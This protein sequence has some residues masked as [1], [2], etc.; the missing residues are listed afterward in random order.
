MKL[1]LAVLTVLA[2]AAP[3]WAAVAPVAVSPG[4]VSKVVR[5]EDRCPTFSWGAVSGA[6]GY[7]LVVY[8]VGEEAEPALRQRI[9]GAALGWTPPLGR[10]LGRGGR[11]AWSVRA[12]ARK[13]ASQWSAPALFEVAVGPSRVEVE[14]A[15]QAL[16]QY[17]EAGGEVDVK[18]IAEA[19]VETEGPGSEATASAPG[20]R[21]V[22]TTQ[23]TV[24]GGVVA[25]SFTGDGSTLTSLTPA[26]LS[27]GTA[28]IDITGKAAN[29][30]DTVGIS[31]GGTGATT[32]PAACAN[33]GAATAA[34][35]AVHASGSD[36]DGRYYTE[37]ELQG[38]G[39]AAVHWNN[40]TNVPPNVA[41]TTSG[42]AVA[43][44]IVK[45]KKAW[46]DGQEITGTRVRFQDNG[47]GTV[48]DTTTGLVWLKDANCFGRRAWPLATADASGL[49][50]P[51]CGLAT[52]APD[53]WRLP[54]IGELWSLI[55]RHYSDPAL[56]NASGTAQWSEG[57]A[58]V[59]VQRDFYWSA[60]EGSSNQ[61]FWIMWAGDGLIGISPYSES[62]RVWP[63]HG[64]LATGP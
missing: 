29:V 7:E 3:S 51:A 13:G 39:S 46:V 4:D 19:R 9:G 40:L 34:S 35:L 56:S 50:P 62:M 41:D 42:D 25:E 27:A 36:H 31:H 2:A 28:A 64:D 55:D 17:V 30:T 16:R 38:D 45:D 60:S 12:L 61:E 33:L 49:A 11:Y 54:N 15:L 1:H 44:E 10:C 23:M 26:N 32:A 22:G 37:G 58:F 63:V 48:T 14:T 52:G 8:R 53:D 57:D 24:D 47:D 18:R 43:G 20:P 5:V 6:R 21:A 59:G